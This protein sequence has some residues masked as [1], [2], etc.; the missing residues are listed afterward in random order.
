[1]RMLPYLNYCP[2]RHSRECQ[3]AHWK[4]GHKLVCNKTQITTDQP[5]GRK[6]EDKLHKQVDNVMRTSSGMF[7][8]HTRSF[9]QWC[10]VN[11]VDPLDCVGTS[12]YLSLLFMCNPPFLAHLFSFAAVANF[13]V[14]P[15]SFELHRTSDFLRT[16]E[17]G[18]RPGQRMHK[19][20]KK[21]FAK[22]R[23]EGSVTSITIMKPAAGGELAAMMLDFPGSRL[24]WGSWQAA[25]EKEKEVM[26]QNGRIEG[27]G[28]YAPPEMN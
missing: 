26:A 19:V 15:P 18:M 16:N 24:R 3:T 2:S 4:S 12:C 23:A 13:L 21:R 6:E 25:L 14:A 22:N 7:M 9:I 1:M 17:C 8:D 28:L 20:A 10:V 5:V 27:L 11:E